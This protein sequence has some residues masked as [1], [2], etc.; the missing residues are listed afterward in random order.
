MTASSLIRADL[1]NNGT[2]NFLP[3]VGAFK[4]VTTQE[5]RSTGGILAINTFLGSDN[6][7]SDQLVINGG[8]GTGLT[9]IRVTNA[10]GP[11]ALTLADAFGWSMRSP[12][13]T[14]DSGAFVLDGRAVAGP[15]EYQLFQGPLAGANDNDWYLRSQ[16]ASSPGD[17]LYRPEIAAYLG[18]SRAAMAMFAHTL[19]ERLGEPQYVDDV[20]DPYREKSAPNRE[21][22]RLGLAPGCGPLRRCRPAW[23]LRI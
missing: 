8:T 17:P 2:V 13:A 6:S 14:T 15:Y 21:R 9:G 3:P 22:S 18:N 16:L 12:V 10:G 5:Y 1:V 11:G 7:P 19:H 4:T 23:Q 20:R